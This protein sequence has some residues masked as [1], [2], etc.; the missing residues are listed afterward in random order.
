[1]ED[2]SQGSRR[3]RI[4]CTPRMPL[5][6]GSPTSSSSNTTRI[7]M[8]TPN[9]SS[10]STNSSSAAFAIGGWKNWCAIEWCGF[11]A[12]EVEGEEGEEKRLSADFGSGVNMGRECQS[13]PVHRGS[14]G[15]GAAL[16]EGEGREETELKWC[17]ILISNWSFPSATDKKALESDL[18]NARKQIHDL[19]EMLEVNEELLREL[20][21]RDQAVEEAVSLICDLEAKIER[22]ELEREAV[23]NHGSQYK[24]DSY[25]EDY[26][27]EMPTN[28]SYSDVTL[29]KLPEEGSENG[30]PSPSMSVL[31]E[32]SFMSIYGAKP[33]AANEDFNSPP[34]KQ[35][36]RTSSSVEKWIDERPASTMPIRIPS[37]S[38]QT[39]LEKQYNNST[40]LRLKTQSDKRDSLHDRQIA[41]E[42]NHR[43]TTDANGFE[44]SQKLPPTPDTFSTGT[45]RNYKNSDDTL[46]Q[47]QQANEDDAKF[48]QSSSTFSVPP[49]TYN[50]Y[51]STTSVRPRSAGETVTSRREG[52]GWDTETM[53]TDELCPEQYRKLRLMRESDDTI[54]P[55]YLDRRPHSRVE[56]HRE[57]D[58]NR[59]VERSSTPIDDKISKP[60]APDR[61]SSLAAATSKLRKHA[62]APIGASHDS[63]IKIPLAPVSASIPNTPS[64]ETSKEK[65]GGKEKDF[66]RLL[67]TRLFFGRSETAPANHVASN[68]I[69]SSSSNS[70]ID[71]R[72]KYQSLPTRNRYGSRRTDLSN[73][74]V[75][76]W[77]DEGRS[78]TPPPIARNRAQSAQT[79]REYG[80]RPRSAA[81]VR[82]RDRRSFGAD[83]AHDGGEIVRNVAG[84]DGERKDAR[85]S[86]MSMRRGENMQV[87]TGQ[88]N[89]REN[90]AAKDKENS[91]SSTPG[92]KWF[93]LAHVGVGRSSSVSKR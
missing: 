36:R 22:L 72:T 16:G 74:Q 7:N 60:S 88:E 68:S 89:H 19:A 67:P 45:L 54:T 17:G 35:H 66:R 62:P 65:E 51:P 3:S 42:D 58:R 12:G 49:A 75:D 46:N 71:Q 29:P 79:Q 18:E 91:S 5:Y 4:S 86:S 69:S 34:P 63:H 87:N 84:G 1:M 48:F 53:E 78:A 13:S 64:R 90:E 28:T 40:N 57:K 77:D 83:G 37:P 76:G 59:E 9:I 25:H 30:M 80:R 55:G 47:R 50:P 27:D 93:G 26:E 52:H 32:S 61:R 21:K 81:G 38:S 33:A 41:K 44:T 15:S 8:T 23:R 39:N 85:G 2:S 14:N 11:V 6:H 73:Y 43:L 24:E 82:E 92:R 31:S 20:E 56:D 70:N 10:Q